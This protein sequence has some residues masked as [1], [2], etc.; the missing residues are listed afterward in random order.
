MSIIGVSSRLLASRPLSILTL[1]P[2]AFAWWDR[3]GL[4]VGLLS[5]RWFGQTTGS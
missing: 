1:M 4:T 3:C 5:S 2:I